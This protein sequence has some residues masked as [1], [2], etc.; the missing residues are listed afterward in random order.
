MIQ[1]KTMLLSFEDFGSLLF[2][3]DCLVQVC[4]KEKALTK[5]LMAVKVTL[6]CKYRIKYSESVVKPPP[7]FSIL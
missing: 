6:F 4:G 1:T 7:G 3:V 2:H 5:K